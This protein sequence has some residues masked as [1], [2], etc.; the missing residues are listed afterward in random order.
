MPP[1]PPTVS[2][3]TNRPVP[4]YYIHADSAHFRDTCGRSILLRGVNLSGAAKSPPS[5]P[6]QKLD[7][8]WENADKESYVGQPLNLDDGTGDV[9]IGK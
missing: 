6:G 5:Q 9:S 1:P 7:G 8:F 3:L 2:H 4:D